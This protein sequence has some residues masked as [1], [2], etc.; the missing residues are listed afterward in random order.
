MKIFCARGEKK[1]AMVKGKEGFVCPKGGKAGV[2]QSCRVYENKKKST[3][4]LVSNDLTERWSLV[5]GGPDSSNKVR[6][7]GK[8]DS[9]APDKKKRDWK[10]SGDSIPLRESP[11]RQLN[12]VDI[13]KGRRVTMRKNFKK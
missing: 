13:L 6:K 2:G 3:S 11:K 12:P 8:G 4:R 7:R 10:R 5:K 1:E 9:L